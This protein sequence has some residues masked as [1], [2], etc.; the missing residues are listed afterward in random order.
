M[1]VI[2]V[3]LIRSASTLQYQLCRE[4]LNKTDHTLIDYWYTEKVKEIEHAI[5]NR[6][7]VPLSIIKTHSY[8][9]IFGSISDCDDIAFLTSYRD[10]R[11]S[12][13]SAMEAYKMPFDEVVSS[14]W[15]ETEMTNLSQLKKLDKILFQNYNQFIHLLPTAVNDMASFL[16]INIEF[17]INEICRNYNKNSQIE[18]I[19]KHNSKFRSKIIDK[20]NRLFQI[21][22]PTNRRKQGL[23]QNIDPKTTLH[24]NH[25]NKND[26]HWNTYFSRHQKDIMKDIIGDWLIEYGFEKDTSW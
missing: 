9:D 24:H 12:S 21:M 11:E 26:L 25:I 8:F 2:C 6:N 22:N 10:L 18:K 23:F 4:L 5:N 15:F 7:S 20:V 13:M 16:Q 17:D 1:L 3:G 14:K 19:E